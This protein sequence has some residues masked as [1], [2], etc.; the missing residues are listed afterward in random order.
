MHYDVLPL[1]VLRVFVLDHHSGS[2]RSRF[3]SLSALSSI[4][5]VTLNE[6]EQIF[7]VSATVLLLHASPDV[8]WSCMNSL[9]VGN[10]ITKI[11]LSGRN[12]AENGLSTVVVLEGVLMFTDPSDASIS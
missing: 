6:L 2:V 8:S 11:S 3:W 9:S 10:R 4:C 5:P 12:D 7:A 1:K